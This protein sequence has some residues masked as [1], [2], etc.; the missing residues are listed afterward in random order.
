MPVPLTKSILPAGAFSRRFSRRVAGLWLMAGWLITAGPLAAEPVNYTAVINP[1]HV[2]VPQFEGWGTSLCWWAHVL[3]SSTNR[4]QYADLAFKKL[5][6]NIVRYNIGG[7]ENPGITNTMEVRARL[8]GFEPRPGVWDWNADANQRWF[9]RSAVAR[10]VNR[11]EAFANSPPYWMTVSGSVT[12]ATN[13]AEDNLRR[14][15]EATF[16]DYL[17]TV[18]SNLTVLDHVTFNTLTPMNEPGSDW[19]H[20]GAR[21]EGTHMSHEQQARMLNQLRPALARYGL[22][23]G[24][25]ASE[26]N[27]EHRAF[28]AVKSYDAATQQLLAH[29]ATHSYTAN[30]P[31]DLRQ[32]ATEIGK[33]LWVTEYGDGQASGLAMARRIRNDL[34]QAR[35][36]AWIY[37]QFAEPDS[38]WGLV[39]YHWSD[40]LRRLSINRKFYVLSQ[41]SQF[42]RPGC[43][44]IDSGDDNSLVAYAPDSCR[45]SI[46][47]VNDH[48]Q[49]LTVVFDLRAF[50]THTTKV[51]R[52]R[53][54]AT[55]NEQE[56]EA[57]AL[58]DGRFTSTLPPRSVTTQVI[59]DIA[60]PV[61]SN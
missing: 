16:A 47:T 5:Q 40:P 29:V 8:P 20:F 21:Q 13:G 48:D 32:L 30:D 37:W 19:W 27:D 2:L 17:A 57:A 42:I 33:P 15:C 43:Q 3:G 56:V 10:G 52:S 34:V 38:N 4:G 31:D 6:L 35:A 1:G 24:L 28:R 55:E 22:D 51:T 46:V 61:A 12:G 49:P 50:Q 59:K 60:S 25:V 53:T 9:L 45:L 39:R 23:T 58:V 36:C 44:I 11:V 14:D 7:G 41:F 18:V 26:D 54:S